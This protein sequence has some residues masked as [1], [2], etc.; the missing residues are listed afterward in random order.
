MTTHAAGHSRPLAERLSTRTLNPTG[1]GAAL[2]DVAATAAGQ[3]P[4]LRA[5]LTVAEAADLLGVS[6]WLVRRLVASGV[7]PAARLGRRIVI[8]RARLLAW[9]DNQQ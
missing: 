5:T 9:L 2:A 1:D 8:Y 7:L 3:P 6:P 4:E